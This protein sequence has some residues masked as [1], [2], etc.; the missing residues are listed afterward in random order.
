MRLILLLALLLIQ[1]CA[2]A[3]AASAARFGVVTKIDQGIFGSRTIDLIRDAGVSVVRDTVSWQKV[4]RVRDRYFWSAQNEAAF[5]ALKDGGISAVLVLT[6]RNDLYDGGEAPKSSSSI[7]AFARF[8]AHVAQKLRGQTVAFEIGNEV[9]LSRTFR[10]ADYAA[11]FVAAANAIHAVDPEVAVVADP[12]VFDNRAAKAIPKLGTPLG[13]AVRR[14]LRVADGVAVHQ[15]PYQRIGMTFAKSQEFMVAA[16]TR[17]AAWLE[18]LAGRPIPLYVTEYGWPQLAG[19][20]L[21]AQEQARQL[22]MT[23]RALA[24]M[25][26]VRMAI[27]YELADSC[28]APAATECTFGLYERSSAGLVAKPALRE[29]RDTVTRFSP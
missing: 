25:P 2:E 27:V 5:L 28:S 4:E 21:G 23:T 10:P 18:V 12:A 6:M 17:R 8:A 7:A 13:D 24:A 3:K 29:F 26:F 20:A 15:Y 9:R 16:M 19:L 22:G 1:P 11:L 14:A